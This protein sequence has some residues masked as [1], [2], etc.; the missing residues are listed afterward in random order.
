MTEV[1]AASVAPLEPALGIAVAQFVPGT[2]EGQNLASMRALAATAVRR[3]ARVVVFPEYAQYFDTV[4]GAGFVAAA[5][6][7]SGSF[8]S[9]LAGLA[10]DFAVHIV[11]GMVESTPERARFS[12]TLV[13]VDPSGHIVATY[14]KQHLYDAFGARES[15]WVVPGALAAPQTFLVHGLRLGLQTCY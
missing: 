4:L 3:G 15:D 2:D 14:R 8:V 10:R 1:S 13:A 5:Q 11:A 7:V 6:P 12:N 9:A